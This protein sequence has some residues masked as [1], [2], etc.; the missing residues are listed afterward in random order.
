MLEG[1]KNNFEKDR[2][3]EYVKREETVGTQ[4]HAKRINGRYI[5]QWTL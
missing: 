1:V 5:A 3:F 4:T 2:F